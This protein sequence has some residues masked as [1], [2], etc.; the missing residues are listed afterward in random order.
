MAHRSANKARLF[1]R[2]VGLRIPPAPATQL[3]GQA[4]LW[5]FE[6]TL[7]QSAGEGGPGRL[8][9]SKHSAYQRTFSLT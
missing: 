3:G 6:V 2:V 1:K 5:T 4:S 8:T 7:S 9:D